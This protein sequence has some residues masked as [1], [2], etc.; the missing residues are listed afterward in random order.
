[1]VAEIPL[2]RMSDGAIRLYCFTEIDHPN[3]F[4]IS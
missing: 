4:G 3:A 2:C 1:M